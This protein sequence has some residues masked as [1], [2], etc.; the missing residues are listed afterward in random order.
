MIILNGFENDFYAGKSELRKLFQ[1]L[2]ITVVWQQVQEQ[3]A[4][5]FE[6]YQTAYLMHDGVHVGIAGMVPSSIM[7][8]VA[9]KGR[10][11][12]F[13]IDGDVLLASGKKQHRLIPLSKYPVVYRDLSVFAPK[14]MTSSTLERLIAAI[15]SRI[16][17]VVLLD[18]FEKKEWQ[19]D[20][21]LTYRFE[22]GDEKT[23][24]GTEIDALIE[25]IVAVLSK[26][27]VRVR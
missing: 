26:H 27:D 22:I 5:W 6:P 17:S 24:V 1:A 3:I 8:Y 10:A 20:R 16:K 18:F 23:L 7:Q 15:D 21:A 11:F 2:G 25:S 12:V 14:S 4:P 19:H 13:E 9:T